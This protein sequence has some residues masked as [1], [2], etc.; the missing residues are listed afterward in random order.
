MSRIIFVITYLFCAVMAQSAF[1]FDEAQDV[2]LGTEKYRIVSNVVKGGGIA[3]GAAHE[4]DINVYY[5]VDESAVTNDCWWYIDK[6][7]D[8]KWRF[9]NA[10]TGQCLRFVT[11]KESGIF[12]RLIFCD[13]SESDLAAWWNVTVNEGLYQFS[14][15]N[16]GTDYYMAKKTNPP[17]IKTD[18]TNG[19]YSCF[20][21]VSENDKT[22][23]PEGNGGNMIVPTVS[24]TL[25]GFVTDM[26]V[27]GHAPA[28]VMSSK[29]YLSVLPH[30][31]NG[32]I[33]EFTPAKDSYKLELVDENDVQVQGI[34]DLQLLSQYLIRVMDENVIV[35]SVPIVFTSMPVL[36]IVHTGALK[37]DM[38]EYVWGTMSLSS[39]EDLSTTI[40]SAKYKTRGATAQKYQSKPSLNMKL[41]ALDGE[42]NEVETDSTLLGLRCASSWILDAMAID[43]IEMRNRVC[44]DIWNEYAPLPYST[45]FGSRN[46]TVGRFIEVVINGVYKGIYC[47]SDKVNRKLLDLKKPQIDET[48]GEVTVRGAIYKHGT[49]SIGDQNTA[50]YFIDYSVYIVGWHDA[51]ELSE[52]EDYPSEA[53]WDGL[54]EIYA[55]KHDLQWISENFYVDQLAKYQ[56]FIA[57]FS[58]GD[59]WGN[60]NSIVSVR[61]MRVDGGKRRFVYTPWDLDT[62]L[63]GS[64][65]GK[66]YDGTYSSWSV[67]NVMS[68]SSKPVP[69]SALGG[70]TDYYSMMRQAWLEGSAGS[71]SV[72]SVKEKLERNRDLFLSSGAWQRQVANRNGAQLCNDL[73]Q[74]ISYIVDWYDTRFKEMD[75]YFGTTDEDREVG[76]FSPTSGGRAD[77]TAVY[78]MQGRLVS[79]NSKT[80]GIYIVRIADGRVV[81]KFIAR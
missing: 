9:R 13:E 6:N 34:E 47:M 18:V 25:D 53:A 61:N 22:P 65:D 20:Y 40:L 8:G 69:F 56:V 2:V 58:I 81:K 48:T 80:P 24:T 66:Y 35:A 12:E 17:M 68:A 3:I 38:P 78:D 63:G 28:Y 16:G 70:G 57:A 73:T 33:F 67:S 54:N 77:A 50:G 72:E 46:G 76:V 43:R 42:G 11:S 31:W 37:K 74:E 55:H 1:A 27:F 29:S 62:A 41:R 26:L 21:L 45:E 30:K 5:V 19:S 36:Q 14:Y 7:Q 79:Q 71:L 15:N 75:A 10:E 51:W 64:Y 52:P 49:N 39:P 23:V 59:N 4:S 44:F 32:G 60:K